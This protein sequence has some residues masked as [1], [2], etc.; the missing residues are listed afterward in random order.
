MR[1]MLAKSPAIRLQI[2][3]ATND[4]MLQIQ[5]TRVIFNWLKKEGQAYPRYPAIRQAFADRFRQFCRFLE[6]ESLGLPQPNQWE[7]TYLNHIP[8]GSVWKAVEDWTFFQPFGPVSQV[9]GTT[10]L[11]SRSGNWHFVIGENAGRLHISWQHGRKDDGQEMIVLNLTAR[12][13]LPGSATD[14]NG[15]LSGLDLGHV[16]IVRSFAAL[17]P[18]ADKYWGQKHAN[19]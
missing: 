1:F 7:L 5:N 6:E 18:D 3:N 11:E 4:G 8:Q 19:G 16:A 9:P 12:G 2:R 14:F 13:P 15:V 10:R 17:I